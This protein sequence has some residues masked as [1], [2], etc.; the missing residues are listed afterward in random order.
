LNIDNQIS[1]LP[2]WRCILQSPIGS[3]VY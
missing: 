2:I 1:L 3:D